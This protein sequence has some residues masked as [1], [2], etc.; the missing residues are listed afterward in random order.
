MARNNTNKQY[1]LRKLKKGTASVAV[2]LSVLGAGLVVNSNEV[3]ARVQTRS[4]TLEKLEAAETANKLLVEIINQHEN[5]K[6]QNG[7][8]DGRTISRLLDEKEE[9]TKENADLTEKNE[10]LE[11]TKRALETEKQVVR[12]DLTAKN[13]ALTAENEALA[14]EKSELANEKAILKQSHRGLSRDLEASRKANE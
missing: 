2:A 5:E 6:I 10:V 11:S 13:D 1:S 14:N 3:S 9:L 7:I 12:A 8:N 4:N